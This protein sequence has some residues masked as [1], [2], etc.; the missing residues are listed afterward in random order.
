M[1][2]L[3]CMLALSRRGSMLRDLLEALGRLGFTLLFVRPY[4]VQMAGQASSARVCGS[5]GGERAGWGFSLGLAAT[6]DAARGPAEDSHV[7]PLTRA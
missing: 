3:C 2:S 1:L 5:R 4:V 7:R 6:A